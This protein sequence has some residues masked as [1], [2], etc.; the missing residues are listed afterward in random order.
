MVVLLNEPCFIDGF[1][2]IE[3]PKMGEQHEIH[4][5]LVELNSPNGGILITSVNKHISR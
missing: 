5:Y 3:R 1:I 2:V 4:W